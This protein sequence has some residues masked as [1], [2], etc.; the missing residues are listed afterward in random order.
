M[1]KIIDISGRRFARL[2]A[3]EHVE[4]SRWRFRCDCGTIK[5]LN[6]DKVIHGGTM[7]CGC[8]RSQSSS[9]R[10]FRHG[11]ARD[12]QMSKTYQCWL[13][14]KN[15]CLNPRT[16]KYSG[17]GGRGVTVC[18]RWLSFEHFFADMGEQPPGHTIERI[19]NAKGYGPDNCKWAT[20][21]EQAHNTRKTKLTVEKAAII[22]QDNRAAR[23]IA[24]D[25][26]I[27]ESLVH[28]VRSGQI[29]KP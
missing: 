21:T 18:E 11:Q 13:N 10:R 29:W 3:I 14:M 17:W 24:K 1:P 15:R 8:L 12:G 20:P 2:I 23:L 27:S 5:V 7:S 28:M 22:R 9:A 16:P 6:R 19:D 26:G 4:G 25:F